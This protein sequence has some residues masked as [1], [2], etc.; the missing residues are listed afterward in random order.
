LRLVSV[1]CLSTVCVSFTSLSQMSVF[2][3]SLG[4]VFQCFDGSFR[5]LNL[6]LFILCYGSFLVQ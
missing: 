4:F 1:W 6:Q 2:F 3:N 5:R